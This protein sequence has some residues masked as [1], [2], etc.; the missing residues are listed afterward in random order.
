[1]LGLGPVARVPVP[2][3]SSPFPVARAARDSKGL[4]LS[5][6]AQIAAEA[7]MAPALLG[8]HLLEAKIILPLHDDHGVFG[9]LA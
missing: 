3:L 4:W 5:S 9:V 6:P 1:M 8:G 2:V 7:P